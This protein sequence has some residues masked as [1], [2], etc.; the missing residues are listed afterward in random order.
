MLANILICAIAHHVVNLA[1]N[2]T[3]PRTYLKPSLLQNLSVFADPSTSVEADLEL[4]KSISFV[5][6][7]CCKRNKIGKNDGNFYK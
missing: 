5:S 3:T 1:F 7:C 4:L 6:S 2:P